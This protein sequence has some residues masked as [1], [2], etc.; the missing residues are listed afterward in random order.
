M[1][2]TGSSGTGAPRDVSQHDV[3]LE[4]LQTAL[5]AR[6]YFLDGRTK[7]QIADEFGMSRFKVAR[8]IDESVTK[9]IVKIDIDVPAEVD[10][11]M[12]EALAERFGLEH[13]IVV[14]SMESSDDIVRE[15]LGKAGA[16]LIAE[17]VEP[18][19]VIGMSWGRTLNQVA[20]YLPPLPPCSVVQIVGGS[21][22]LAVS[23]SPQDLVRRI[24]ERAQGA[25]HSLHAP[26]FVDD[27]AVAR[28]V[29]ESQLVAPTLQ[30]YA[31]LTLAVVA[32]GSWT[33]PVSCLYDSLDPKA[34][35]RLRQ[36]G[37]CAD[38]CTVLLDEAGEVVP[39]DFY[40]R[41]I[42][43][44]LEQLRR[45]PRVLAV[46]GGAGKT[47]AVHA[48]LRSGLL[49]SLVTDSLVAKTILDQPNP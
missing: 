1:A 44:S 12:S 17:I 23:A 11:G 37:T 27:V 49:H 15:Q 41:T 5:L 19:D 18:E 39:A 26:M 42:G 45:V 30:R 14:A 20:R 8:L 43:I 32:I 25:Q 28:G 4:R 10:L 48:A 34:R 22:V 21:P 9:G 16:R 33:P 7:S 13:S 3:P 46:A 24:G 38:V 36:L 2:A 6:R 47:Q 29:R 31:D 40:D 35:T